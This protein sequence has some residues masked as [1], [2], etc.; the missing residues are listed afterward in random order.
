VLQERFVPAEYVGALTRHG[1]TLLYGV[2]TMY[3]LF[4]SQD[5]PLDLSSIRLCFSAAA[6]LPVDVER[7]WYER[8]GHRI[9][10]GYGLTECSPFASWNRD[11]DVRPGS[12]GTP[13]AVKEAAV[14]GVPD[15]VRGEAVKAFVVLQESGRVTAETLQGLCRKRSH[16]TRCREQ[17]SSSVPCRRTRRA[18]S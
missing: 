17:S 3:I 16:P 9:T 13:I 8:Y 11:V 2:P 18:R 12:V 14:I 10:Q 6:T 7:R 4:L 15:A 1:I 5:E